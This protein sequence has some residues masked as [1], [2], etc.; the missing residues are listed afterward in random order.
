MKLA[1]QKALKIDAVSRVEKFHCS[2]TTAALLK[3]KIR[4]L[5]LIQDVP[6]RW[7]SAADML[8][9]YLH[10]QPTI[11]ATLVSNDLNTRESDV[12]MLSET[13]TRLAHTIME[14]LIPL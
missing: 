12:S 11:Y 2:T 3:S 1:A 13:D 14:G 6:T 5:K 4:E 9:R 10:L 8:E 7:N